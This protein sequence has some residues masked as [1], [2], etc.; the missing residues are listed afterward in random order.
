MDKDFGWKVAA[1]TAAVGILGG[2]AALLIGVINAA[3]QIV[4]GLVL[5]IIQVLF[6]LLSVA[7]TLAVGWWSVGTLSAAVNKQFAE[8]EEKYNEQ[9]K[10]LRGKRPAWIATLLFLTEAIM[11][12]VD[13]SFQGNEKATLL[14]SFP[15]L[16]GFWVANQL[17]TC[18][19]R[20]QRA[21]GAAV[22]FVVLL[23]LP[24]FVALDRRL[25]FAE[26]FAFIWSFE[27]YVKIFAL[28]T[29]L[30]LIT[31]PTLALRAGAE[32]EAE[33]A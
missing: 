9:F 26:F 20:W 32:A 2:G 25:N 22:W 30:S 1:V 14:A 12:L 5:T 31:L 28:V 29:F 33:T 4:S 16:I 23:A 13:K 27:L 15:M 17:M 6:V 7:L 10:R 19:V 18:A 3:G 8:L 21:I 11:V 24:F